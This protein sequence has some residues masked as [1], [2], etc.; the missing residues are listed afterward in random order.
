MGTYLS[1]MFNTLIA[2]DLTRRSQA[3]LAILLAQS[4]W[5]I[6][7]SAPEGLNAQRKQHQ[8]IT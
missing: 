3:S 5:I 8:T 2:G 6:P 4:S 7:V 1:W